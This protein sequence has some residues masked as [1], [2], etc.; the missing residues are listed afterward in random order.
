M[1]KHTLLSM[2]ESPVKTGIIRRLDSAGKAGYS[3]LLE[4]AGIDRQLG[5]TGAF[6]YH[7]KQLEREGII[8][9]SKGKDIMAAC[10]QLSGS[11]LHIEE[12]ATDVR[13]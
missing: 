13:I 6:N 2:I 4:S 11:N 12:P 8:R 1:R 5:G 3:D 7:L 10:G 9:K